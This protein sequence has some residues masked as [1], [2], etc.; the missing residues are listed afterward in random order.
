MRLYRNYDPYAEPL[1]MVTSFRA[2]STTVPIEKG[3]GLIL[4]WQ[5]SSGSIFAGGD[6]RILR[7]WDAHQECFCKVC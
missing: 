2:L 4:D 7:I 6:A 5:Q 1:Q 3:C